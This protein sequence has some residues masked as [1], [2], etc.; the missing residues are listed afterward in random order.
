MTNGYGTNLS[1]QATLTVVPV[2]SFNSGIGWTHTN[3]VAAS[4]AWLGSNSV[5]L[6]ADIG[7]EASSLFF[8]SPMYI[9]G[10]QASYTYQATGA[11]STLADGV[12]FCIQNDS[13]GP[14][15]IGGAGG[16]LG[17]SGITPSVELE[18]NIYP[19][20]TIGINFAT[21]GFIA[22]TYTPPG[23]VTLNSGDPINTVITYA[24]GLVTVVLTDQDNG[25]TF[26]TNIAANIPATVGGNTAYVGFTAADG[27]S[28]A[29]QDISNFQIEGLVAITAQ[30]SGG[31]LL[32]SWPTSAGAYAVASTTN[33]MSPWTVISAPQSLVNNQIQVSVPVPTGPAIFYKLVLQ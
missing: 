7:S 24:N 19:S 31:N 5:Q 2:L 13:R 4:F 33:L 12:T 32:L 23:P 1:S 9:G 3:I 18:F 16:S 15:A 14:A 17:V 8:D 26:T 25:A 27:G 10:F 6:T 20:Y 21:N 28:E 29:F 22:S 30:V 11:S